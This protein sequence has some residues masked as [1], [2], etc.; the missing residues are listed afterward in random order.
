[1]M[2]IVQLF[3]L[4]IVSLA[5]Q[6]NASQVVPY[7]DRSRIENQRYKFSAEDRLGN[8][9]AIQ[10]EWP[11]FGRI[12]KTLSYGK[13]DFQV[14]FSDEGFSPLGYVGNSA[15]YWFKKNPLQLR[16]ISS[17]ARLIEANQIMYVRDRIAGNYAR[18]TKDFAYLSTQE[19]FLRYLAPHDLEFKA[20]TQKQKLMIRGA[21]S[22]WDDACFVGFEIGLVRCAQDVEMVT[23]LTA[24]EAITLSGKQDNVQATD[25]RLFKVYPDGLISIFNELLAQKSFGIERNDTAFLMGDSKIFVNVPLKI[26]AFQVGSVSAYV[27]IPAPQQHNNKKLIQAYVGD[28]YAGLGVGVSVGFSWHVTSLVNPHCFSVAQYSFPRVISRR[29]PRTVERFVSADPIPVITGPDVVLNLP[30]GASTIDYRSYAAFSVPD[31]AIID[32]AD[33]VIS[34]NMRRGPEVSV[35]LGNVF[36]DILFKGLQFDAS[37]TF[38]FKANDATGATNSD[39]GYDRELAVANSFS[40]S[41]VLSLVASYEHTETVG[42]TAGFDYTFAGRRCLKEI[43]GRIGI[44]GVF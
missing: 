18:E 1:M 31:S 29:V 13:V 7:N 21:R 38:K 40:M 25:S 35:Q 33:Q 28:Q 20:S 5:A 15:V 26:D 42:F 16:D 10:P 32:F 4:C 39:A 44:F 30:L 27:M 2:K 19:H 6:C 37:Y 24:A 11:F 41:H 34:M 22:C 36:Q 8:N 43:A 14:A 17:L 3:L 12:F 23:A 9:G